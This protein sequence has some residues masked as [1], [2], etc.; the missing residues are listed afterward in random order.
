MSFRCISDIPTLKLPYHS[1]T[2][3][4]YPKRELLKKSAKTCENKEIK[5]KKPPSYHINKS[6]SPIKWVAVL[7]PQSKSP[8]A[9]LN[10]KRGHCNDIQTHAGSRR[11]GIGKAL[12]L[13]C[14]KDE[15]I[16]NDGG[17]NPLTDDAW[18]DEKLKSTTRDMCSAIVLIRCQ[19]YHHTPEIACKMYMEAALESGYGI[20]FVEKDGD[21]KYKIF[22]VENAKPIFERNPESFL[23][24][25]GE[26]WFFCKCKPNKRQDC[27][28]TVWYPMIIKLRDC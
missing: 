14:L 26:N 13:T 15:D 21:D 2:L 9:Y 8:L 11:C 28:G 5:N 1:R 10:A 22:R 17:L 16:V 6:K 24:E 27:L 19:P 3:I 12:L 23:E 25:N 20:V 18:E 7:E 4:N